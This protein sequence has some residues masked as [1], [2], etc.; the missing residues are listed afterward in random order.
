MVVSLR[1]AQELE[2]MLGAKYFYRQSI[3]RL[4]EDGLIGSYEVNG[5]FCF[6]SEE[7]IN[8]VLQRL[9]KRI[10]NRFSWILTRNLRIK[11]D[12]SQAQEI[13]VY[14]FNNGLTITANT[15][16]E[17]EEDLLKKIENQGEE[18]T[19]MPDIAV[20]PNDDRPHM[21]PTVPGPGPHHGPKLGP[22]EHH[23]DVMEALRR[24]EEGLRRIEEKLGR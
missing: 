21:P 8:Q 9:A 20:G 23:H 10:K 13:I 2:E 19:K 3:Y 4:A 12:E 6:S 15:K 16:L 7:V 24:L 17:T 11:Y 18:V 5:I 22:E 14:G 1:T